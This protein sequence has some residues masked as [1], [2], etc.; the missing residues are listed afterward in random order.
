MNED[1]ALTKGWNGRIFC[2]LKAVKAGGTFNGP[3]V[4]CSGRHK[5]NWV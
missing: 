5:V 4:G 1:I 2:E 3:F